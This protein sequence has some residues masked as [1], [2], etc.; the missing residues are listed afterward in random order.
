MSRTS[1][2]ILGS[3][4][5]LFAWTF[6]AGL[7]YAPKPWAIWLCAGFCVLI[8][9]ACFS[10][11]A[12]GAALRVIGATVFVVYVFAVASALADARRTPW[13]GHFHGRWLGFLK[14]VVEGF[15]IYGLP[16]LYVALHGRYPIWGRLAGAFLGKN[17]LQEHKAEQ[18]ASRTNSLLP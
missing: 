4:A 9:L 13:D 2:W 16:G 14:A 17:Y 10:A 5:L 15:L 7:P 11:V 3:F 6:I 18:E 12:R 8:A 1:R